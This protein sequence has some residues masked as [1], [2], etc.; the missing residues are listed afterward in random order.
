MSS[1]SISGY[2]AATASSTRYADEYASSFTPRK[3]EL[4]MELTKVKF[5]TLG[6]IIIAVIISS[7]IW[8]AAY[9]LGDLN[10]RYWLGITFPTILIAACLGL[11]V[12]FICVAQAMFSPRDMP[13]EQSVQNF[14]MVLCL[15][16]T[17]LALCFMIVS[18]PIST[19]AKA[20]SDDISY[21]CGSSLETNGLKAYY[22]QLLALRESEGCIDQVSVEACEGFE[23]VEPYTSYLQS[24]EFQYLCSGFCYDSSAQATSLAAVARVV[25]L[26]IA[27]ETSPRHV[28][29]HA[30]I[31]RS[32]HSHRPPHW[33]S[34]TSL[35]AFSQTAPGASVA[36]GQPA[37][38]SYPPM[39]FSNSDQHVQKSC[40][41]AA[42]R[43]LLFVAGDIAATWWSSGLV[44]LFISISIGMFNWSAMVAK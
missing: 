36:G 23:A 39:L 3:P 43:S 28:H 40:D 13:V 10:S 27:A 2:G 6:L 22:T 9:L 38:T 34:A 12:L 4:R 21:L 15:L 19:Q 26:P 41:G 29:Q 44:L 35:A 33:S 24:L 25:V 14:V 37:A 16:V 11:L 20:V 8:D 17:L 42:S 5:M 7:P 32:H 1:P 30:D 18:M 31:K